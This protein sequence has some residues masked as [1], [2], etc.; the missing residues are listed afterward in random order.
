MDYLE[1]NYHLAKYYFN[2]EMAGREVVLFADKSIIEDI[3]RKYNADL[4]DFIESIK[5]GPDGLRKSGLCMKAYHLFQGWRDKRKY[6]PYIAYLVLFVIAASTDTDT[7]YSDKAY[8]PGL[9]KLL[10]LPEGSGGP[11]SF[12]K[13]RELWDDLEK[14]SREELES[15]GRFSAR[16]LGPWRHVGLPQSQTLMTKKERRLL[17]LFFDEYGFDPS[18]IP[19]ESKL[20][21][22]LADSRILHQRT[23]KLLR[24]QNK[25]TE[26]LRNALME[27]VLEDL[28]LWDGAIPET[29]NLQIKR[30]RGVAKLCLKYDP[31]A[32]MATITIRL[33]TNCPFPDE[34][35]QIKEYDGTEVW[36]CTEARGNWS[37]E[38]LSLSNNSLLNAST[39]DWNKDKIFIEENTG[40]RIKLPFSNVRVFS[41]GRNEGFSQWLEI[42]KIESRVEYYIACHSDVSSSVTKWGQESAEGFREVK[43]TGLPLNWRLYK[44]ASIIKSHPDIE[45]LQLS[46]MCNFGLTSGIKAT[47]GNTYFYF[48]PPE[49]EVEGSEYAPKVNGLELEKKENG[50]WTIPSN[51]PLE[52]RIGVELEVPGKLIHRYFELT[53]TAIRKDYSV[54]FRDRFGCFSGQDSKTSFISGTNIKSEYIEN[55]PEYPFE[56]PTYLSSR[57]IILGKRPGEFADWPKDFLP[58][59]WQPIWV[60]A[61]L[62]RDKWKAFFVGMDLLNDFPEKGRLHQWKKWKRTLTGIQ[63]ISPSLE[64]HRALWKAYQ[65]EAKKI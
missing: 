50:K 36:T 53:K 3:G 40:W 63:V 24:D 17:P 35:M 48:A 64:N 54:H 21:K 62:R 18:S 8:Y 57:L 37:R 65:K 51:V 6:P 33:K 55:I 14:W 52:T 28:K 10:G 29:D 34:E 60:V 27:L 44:V 22:A 42:N 23:R 15:I 46:T 26:H 12:E 16:I 32:Q 45:L 2:Q 20:K 13:M 56:I 61:K 41:L 31:F 30:I 39:L 11:A 59:E 4:E 5:L 49:V 9:N 7:D 1:W 43:A 38:F 58:T 47:R 25:D 19:G